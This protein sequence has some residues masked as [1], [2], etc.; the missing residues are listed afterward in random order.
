MF[1][2]AKSFTYIITI[3]MLFLYYSEVCSYPNC[4][5]TV[6]ITRMYLHYFTLSIDCTLMNTNVIYHF[7]TVSKNNICVIV[8]IKLIW[9]QLHS[10]LER[11]KDYMSYLFMR[12]KVLQQSSNMQSHFGNHS[13]PKCIHCLFAYVCT[14][15][16]ILYLYN[17]KFFRI[18]QASI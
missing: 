10:I 9:H 7:I 3:N 14:M 6:S 13:W 11:T 1:Y 18:S 17:W 5:K 4:L 12:S 16:F 8:D 15:T 2:F